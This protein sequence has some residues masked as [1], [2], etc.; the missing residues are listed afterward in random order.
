MVRLP[1][2]DQNT[3]RR[4]T[5]AEENRGGEPWQTVAD[6]RSGGSFDVAMAQL[7]ERKITATVK[8][9]KEKERRLRW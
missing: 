2:T 3:G 1:R 5:I 7:V 9:D 4:G 8:V 6:V